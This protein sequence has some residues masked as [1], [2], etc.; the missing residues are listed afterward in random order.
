[1]YHSLNFDLIIMSTATKIS[2][3]ERSSLD[4]INVRSGLNY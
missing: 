2:Y 1:M 4:P 3:G